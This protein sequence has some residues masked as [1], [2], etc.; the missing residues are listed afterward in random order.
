[1]STKQIFKIELTNVFLTEH[2]IIIYKRHNLYVQRS[3]R[4][5]LVSTKNKSNSIEKENIQIIFKLQD[6]IWMTA[7]K[8]LPVCAI[9]ECCINMINELTISKIYIRKLN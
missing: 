3:G 2:K 6:N 1:M 9:Q 8:N 5:T 4:H 7:I